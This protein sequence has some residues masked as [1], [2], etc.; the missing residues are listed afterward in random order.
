MLFSGVDRRS[1]YDVTFCPCIQVCICT[2]TPYTD[3][4]IV[5]VHTSYTG[6]TCSRHGRAREVRGERKYE[7]LLGTPSVPVVFLFFLV[8]GFL[9]PV[10]LH[11]RE[12]FSSVRPAPPDVRVC[13]CTS[14][15][16]CASY[17][18]V[19][20]VC[21]L[22]SLPICNFCSRKDAGGRNIG[23]ALCHSTIAVEQA[24]R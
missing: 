11:E 7:V 22:Q 8:S 6:H 19:V 4:G 16:I 3:R 14:T 2:C 17:K 13:R 9:R 23:N 18:Y 20:L 10:A 5:Y 24:G 1:G 15:C 12:T 21:P